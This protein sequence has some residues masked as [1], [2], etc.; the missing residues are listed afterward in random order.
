MLLVPKTM[1]KKETKRE[2]ARPI[3][4]SNRVANARPKTSG[5]NAPRNYSRPVIEQRREVERPRQTVKK[6]SGKR[7]LKQEEPKRPMKFGNP[8]ER[9]DRKNVTKMSKRPSTANKRY[10]KKVPTEISLMDVSVDSF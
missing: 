3:K 9:S 6:P 5:P 4:E 1:P 7:P 10:A 8:E 2:V